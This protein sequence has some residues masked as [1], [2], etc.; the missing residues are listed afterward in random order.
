MNLSVS[1]I[2]ACDLVKCNTDKVVSALVSFSTRCIV[3]Q[4]ISAGVTDSS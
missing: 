1:I 2:T 3:Q 4:L